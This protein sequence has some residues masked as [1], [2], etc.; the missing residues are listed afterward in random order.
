MSRY[1]SMKSAAMDGRF[2]ILAFKDERSNANAQR[3]ELE[4][5]KREATRQRPES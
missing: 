2:L 3:S 4:I 1:A 5:S